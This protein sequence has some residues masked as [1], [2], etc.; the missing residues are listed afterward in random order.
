MTLASPPFTRVEAE[1][2]RNAAQLPSS[3]LSDVTGRHCAL[4]GRIQALRPG[5]RVAGPAF[6]VAVRP[7]DNLA[8]HFALLLA[9]PG[10]VLV[11]D[12]QGDLRSA[13][14][15]ELMCAH[16]A[17][18]GLAGVVIDGA[19]RDSAELRVGTL[20][21]FASGANPNGPTRNL[22]GRVAVPVS[23]GGVSVAPGDLIVGDDDGLVALASAQVPEAIRLG[24][25]KLGSEAQRRTDIAE[26]RLV[27][28]WLEQALR[29]NG[30]L[31]GYDSLQSAMDAFAAR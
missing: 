10:D 5:M 3:I 13:L 17:Q 22:A 23:V 28:G 31:E 20:P 26:N 29:S 7:G 4:H 27:Y 18:A 19:V 24:R 8:I 30:M 12:G 25:A 21:V 2:V 14:M 9:Q 6:T 11:V 15:G 16:A 1:L